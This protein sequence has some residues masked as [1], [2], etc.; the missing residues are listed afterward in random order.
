M[1]GVRH[2]TVADPDLQIEGGGGGSSIIMCLTKI[3]DQKSISADVSYKWRITV[4][5]HLEDLPD[6][7]L[8]LTNL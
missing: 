7:S 1:L 4:Y 5:K 8:P 3:M 2:W 6:S